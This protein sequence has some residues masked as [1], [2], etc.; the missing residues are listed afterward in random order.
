MFADPK[1]KIANPI[2]SFPV[3]DVGQTVMRKMTDIM[4]TRDDMDDASRKLVLQVPALQQSMLHH[5]CVIM[6]YAVRLS[7]SLSVS[8]VL[9]LTSIYSWRLSKEINSQRARWTRKPD[10]CY[11][12]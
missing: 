7:S 9:L 6:E 8:Y 4:L 10:Y 11:Y 3:A 1:P 5:K 12:S 2:A